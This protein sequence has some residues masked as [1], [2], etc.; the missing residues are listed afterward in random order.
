MEENK[1][2][3]EENKSLIEENKHSILEAELDFRLIF[4]KIIFYKKL[5]AKVTIL[6]IILGFLNAFTAKKVWEGGFEIV[7]SEKN[8]S[9]TNNLVD[10]LNLGN[11]AG[12]KFN[13]AKLNTEVQILQSPSVLMDTFEF[14]KSKTNNQKLRF[15]DWKN[16]FTFEL[17]P[18]TSILDISYRD[19]DKKLIQETLN[20]IS[21]TYQKYSGIEREREIEL[22]IGFL[23]EQL[24]IYKEKALNS[25]KETQEFAFNNDLIPPIIVN[26]NESEFASLGDPGFNLSSERIKAINQIK[27]LKAKKLQLEK[28]DLNDEQI[29]LYAKQ[30]IPGSQTLIKLNK[31]N[32]NLSSLQDIYTEKDISII[33]L[34][35]L[36]K[37]LIKDIKKQT[38]ETIIASIKEFEAILMSTER[39]AGVLGKYSQLVL[40]A[41]Q[42]QFAYSELEKQYRIM[43]LERARYKDPWKLITEPTII[44]NPVKPN[45]A[46]IITI[47][48]F[49]GFI[50]GIFLSLYKNKIEDLVYSEIEL[51]KFLSYKVLGNLNESEKSEYIEDLDLLLKPFM[52]KSK[53]IT[54]LK[55]LEINDYRVEE[56][57]KL[58][59]EQ[60]NDLNVSFLNNLRDI[61]D[62]SHLILLVE[63]GFSKKSS[64]KKLK[65]KLLM[66]GIKIDG[67]LILSKQEINNEKSKNNFFKNILKKL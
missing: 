37:Q 62:E 50:L 2:L 36:K 45:K 41:S 1:N 4:E 13:N 53:T 32:S 33:S 19:P 17:L 46:L 67:I 21:R 60:F 52:N 28:S 56:M 7:I 34:K 18:N 26:G 51:E 65:N 57:R 12:S 30:S 47:S 64:I 31:I 54:F 35:S 48:T 49:I 40:Q 9:I 27:I 61:S 23:N 8:D 16:K 14:V 20:M 55:L 42:D 38:Y 10:R 24:P 59:K 5:I 43:L 29:I 66:Q 15:N 44:P 6:G 3:I 25:T 39:P 63:L 11:I 58:I 22:S